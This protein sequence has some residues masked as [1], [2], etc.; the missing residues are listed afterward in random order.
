[1][2]LRSTWLFVVVWFLLG[3]SNLLAQCDHTGIVVDASG[4]S[5][6]E[7][8]VIDE[9]GDVYEPLTNPYGLE[10][11]DQISFSALPSGASSY[12]QLGAAVYLN[13][14]T[15]VG[16][17]GPVSP[18]DADFSWKVDSPTEPLQITFQAPAPL[19]GYAYFWQTTSGDTSNLSFPTFSFPAPDQYQVCL[20]VTGPDCTTYHCE[21]ITAGYGADCGFMVDL[22][23]DGMTITAEVYNP[24]DFGPYHPQV[25]Q[26]YNAVTWEMIGTEPVLNYT[27]TDP[28]ECG[29]LCAFY[30]VIFPGGSMCYGEVCE[31]ILVSDGCFDPGA[32]DP[33]VVC[34]T[35]YDPVCG[36]DGAT[37]GNACEAEN[38]YGVIEYSPGPCPN[39]PSC[40]AY[41]MTSA[42]ADPMT[43][44]FVNGS[45]L[46]AVEWSWD[47]SD[48]SV[49]LNEDA[50]THTFSEPGIY[51][52]C[53]EVTGPGCSAVYCRDVVV[54]M[55]SSLEMCGFTDC[56]WPGD[57]NGDAKADIYDLL[58]LGLGY[59]TNGPLRPAANT[60]WEGQYAPDWGTPIF[61]AVDE[62]HLDANGD[63][64]VNEND[65]EAISLNYAPSFGVSS[66]LSP[67]AP[68][69]Y[70]DFL[71]DTLVIDSNSP[72][73]VTVNARLMAGD[74]LLPFLD[75]HGLAVQIY[76]PQQ[77]LVLP[78]SL[79]AVPAPE[80]VFG[81]E[82]DQ[83]WMQ[84]DLYELKRL[85]LAFTR[86]K[87]EIV[88]GY[89]AV[90]EMQ[91]IVISDII[92]GRSENEIPFLM[93]IEG[94]K[95]V[96]GMGEPKLVNVPAVPS[97]FLIINN[98]DPTATK[99]VP[100]AEKIQIYPNPTND[101]TFVY[102]PP[103]LQATRIELINAQGQRL[104]SE[105]VSEEVH[106]ISAN[107]LA[108]GIYWVQVQTPAGVV[109]R[110][111][112]VE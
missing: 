75:L 41:F 35:V 38:W 6:C 94:V 82:Q 37:Y 15:V 73:F 69:L 45:T 17:A 96:N 81:D 68:V 13:C 25:V 29:L 74:A 61:A 21:E 54:N 106:P 40:F 43:V 87:G 5:S 2:L 32:I 93:H 57:A 109:G 63:G 44:Q 110:K 53:L 60:E 52:V 34:A 39:D 31:P 3:Q 30:E 100:A 58:E 107:Q 101:L 62:K 72:E 49:Y 91:F 27:L 8:V 85:D 16:N 80:S 112:V 84:K 95:A 1:M 97:S 70:I 20:T 24:T 108:S 64:W 9:N 79:E 92:G 78:H 12:C 105:T 28:E 11:G 76:Y 51:P 65:Q 18:C 104:L 67:D 59:Q 42:T 19:P 26:W 14:V 7:L 102:L 46:G 10:A 48:G 86:K 55:T 99:D 71:V 47:F 23:V 33:E 22:Q 36:C 83:L 4:V 98:L 111:L 89:G 50:P 66:T 88:N 90:A 77:D 103:E 56:V